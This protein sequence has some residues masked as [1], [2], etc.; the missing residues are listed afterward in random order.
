MEI[1]LIHIT[2]NDNITFKIDLIVWKLEIL[3]K[4]KQQ[5]IMFKIDLIVWKYNWLHL[6]SLKIWV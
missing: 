6:K 5:H 2:D 4:V 1:V 3:R